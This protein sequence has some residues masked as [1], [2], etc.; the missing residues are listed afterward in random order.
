[1]FL[2]Y[3]I[4][5]DMKVMQHWV[6]WARQPLPDGRTNKLPINPRTG[7]KAQSNNPTTWTDFETAAAA[8]KINEGVQTAGGIIC[9]LGFMLLN[10]G[11]TCIDLDHID[12][13]EISDYQDGK[14]HINTVLYDVLMR[15]NVHCYAEISQSGRGIHI[16]VKGKLP[17]GRRKCNGVEMYDDA[18]GKARF[19][20]MTG[21]LLHNSHTMLDRDMTA[22]LKALHEKYMPQPTQP[23]T[24]TGSNPLPSLNVDIQKALDTARRTNRKFAAL[25]AGDRTAYISA[26]D[27][28]GNNSSDQALCDILCFYLG[29]DPAKIDAAFRQ[30]GLMR[31]KWDRKTGETTYG[32]MTINKAINDSSAY[33]DYNREQKKIIRDEE[34]PRIKNRNVIIR[35]KR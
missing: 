32:E 11:I 25:W 33:F 7:N 34:R 4:P 28:N 1:M 14:P 35:T 29:G 9:G 24:G 8:F 23:R 18:E 30:S 6:L 27:P 16:F 12:G 17:A 19:I 3:N 31:E 13:R 26:T 5:N 2:S 20:A 21:N 22:E 10:S 15:L